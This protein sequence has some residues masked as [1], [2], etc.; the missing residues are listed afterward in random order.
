MQARKSKYSISSTEKEVVKFRDLSFSANHLRKLNEHWG[1]GVGGDVTNSIYQ[2][3]DNRSSLMPR[4]EYSITPYSK[5]NSDRIVVRYLAGPEYSN[6]GDT[7]IFLKTSEW[8]VKQSFQAIAS[9]TKPWGSV[10]IGGFWSNYLSD[11][12][13]NNLSFN[14]GVSWRIFKGLQFGVGG[15]YSFVRDQIN[16][17]KAGASSTDILTQRRALLSNYDYFVGVGFSYTFGSIFNNAVFPSFRGLNW[18]LNF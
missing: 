13:K 14:G 6:Y 5:F 1:V 9:F 3:L 8:Q 18:G 15:N 17:K 11:F 12:K 10:N 16:I 4:V 7:T 2:N